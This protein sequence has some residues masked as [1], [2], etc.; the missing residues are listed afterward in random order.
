MHGGN[1]Q[2][3]KLLMWCG[4]LGA[5]ICL[6]T[7][8]RG[9]QRQHHM[10]SACCIPASGRDERDILDHAKVLVCTFSQPLQMLSL[11]ALCKCMHEGLTQAL[12]RTAAGFA[13]IRLIFRASFK[14]KLCDTNSSDLSVWSSFAPLICICTTALN[15]LPAPA[16]ADSKHSHCKWIQND[17]K[18]FLKWFGGM[19]SALLFLYHPSTKTGVW[20]D[21]KSCTAG[22]EWKEPWPCLSNFTLSSIES[23]DCVRFRVRAR[24]LHHHR[25]QIQLAWGSAWKRFTASRWKMALRGEANHTL[26]SG[27]ATL[28]QL[29]WKW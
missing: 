11:K 3:E 2:I 13:K 19:P 23:I 16:F 7:R 22:I 26:P 29:L 4:W 1:T 9:L 24:V 25:K 27:A 12:T 20:L 5:W 14:Y 8:A 6:E 28:G 21:G 18:P 17:S 15:G 10:H